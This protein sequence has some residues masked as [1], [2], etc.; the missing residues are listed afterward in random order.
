[1]VVTGKK[2]GSLHIRTER[3]NEDIA[4]ATDN[5]INA[6]AAIF[7]TDVERVAARLG[8]NLCQQQL[9]ILNQLVHAAVPPVSK[10][11]AVAHNGFVS[12]YDKRVTFE[13]VRQI[14][15][16]LSADLNHP[17][18][19]ASVYDDDVFLFGLCETGK[20]VSTYVGGNCEA[21]GLMR[22]NY[23]IEELERCLSHDKKS[24]PKLSN[25]TEVEFE[26]ALTDAFGFRLD[27]K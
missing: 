19:F 21:Y 13:N 23:N 5:C 27:Q 25:L 12:V 6:V 3:S 24:S 9:P 20:T 4:A 15:Q 8:L 7:G 1:M 2:Y 10:P 22:E 17:V 16:K 11:T 18:V 14:A 26:S